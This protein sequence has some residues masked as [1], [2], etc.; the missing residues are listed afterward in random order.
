MQVGESRVMPLFHQREVWVSKK[1]IVKVEHVNG[2]LYELIALKVGVVLVQAEQAQKQ[3]IVK[4]HK[5]TGYTSEVCGVAGIEC[6]S[7]GIEG[8]T[9]DLR[10]FLRARRQCR[11]KCLFALRLTEAT[12]RAWLEST[13]QVLGSRYVLSARDRSGLLA[14]THCQ[15][16]DGMVARRLANSLTN[17]Y[18]DQS[19]LAVDCYNQ[20]D[21]SA[22]R[23]TAKIILVNQTKARELGFEDF[24]KLLMLE[25]SSLRLLQLHRL[26]RIIG[27]PKF[28]LMNGAEAKFETGGE[29]Q[30]TSDE[31]RVVW[32]FY[33]LSLRVKVDKVNDR[34][35]KLL[36]D[37]SLKNPNESGNTSLNSSRFTSTIILQLT[38]P[39]IVSVIGYQ[40]DS[41]VR[42]VLPFLN[43]LPII[44]ILF[45]RKKSEIAQ[46]KIII[47]FLLDED[48]NDNREFWDFYR[49][50]CLD[51]DGD[52]LSLFTAGSCSSGS[53][54]FRNVQTEEEV[55]TSLVEP[56]LFSPRQTLSSLWQQ[57]QQPP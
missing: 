54:N 52:N 15:R 12:M 46:N 44:G 24:Q 14:M 34:Q 8:Q 37:F 25:P 23:L 39:K 38:Q 47:W 3:F 1:G 49:Q 17:G 7:S 56:S 22:Y 19:L 50:Q 20:F 4:V 18:V 51:K 57:H 11:K 29:L 2:N 43:K 36:L 10:L 6:S 33:G 26:S 5:S 41:S 45:N 16:K 28:S 48:N 32:K 31:E 53:A 21:L 42:N 27:Q 55:S 30:Y 35:A 13:Q 40:N 9:A